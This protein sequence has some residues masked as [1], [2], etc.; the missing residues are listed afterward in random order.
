MRVEAEGDV[1]RFEVDDDGPGI[2]TA[3]QKKIFEPSLQCESAA[4]GTA[5]G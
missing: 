4:A 5:G 2:A 3:D 1:V